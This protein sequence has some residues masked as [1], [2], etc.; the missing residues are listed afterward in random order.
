M[1]SQEAA[2]RFGSRVGTAAWEGL[3]RRLAVL[4]GL[5]YTGRDE[6]ALFPPILLDPI[7]TDLL[8]SRDPEG[9]NDLL[10]HYIVL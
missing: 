3:Q 6:V 10:A 5:G 1:S 4:K 9:G 2:L 7:S 8:L